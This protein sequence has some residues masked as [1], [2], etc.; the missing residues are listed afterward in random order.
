MQDLYK[1]GRYFFA[2]TIIA[3]GVI[4]FITRNFMTGFLPV[5]DDL[6]GR[7]FFLYVVSTLFLAG[8]ILMFPSRTSRRISILIG[9]LF[10]VFLVYPDLVRLFSDLHQPNSWTDIAETLGLGGGAFMIAGDYS[11][12][13]ASI[14]NEPL[15]PK[16]MRVGTIM[17][18]IG[19]LIVAVQHFMYA[20]FIGTLIPAWIP[21]PVF[22]AYF[23]GVAFAA[24]CISLLINIKTKLACILLGLMFLFWVVFL[25]GPRAFTNAHKEAEW[26][27]LF[28]ALGFSGVFF[29]IVS[30]YERKV[31]A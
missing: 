26:S 27:S 7:I 1:S 25:H 18:A 6:P 30:Q 20:D 29:T 23:V 31:I 28:M 10:M 3:F 9:I 12:G 14:K 8:G 24:T 13:I 22:W 19:L 2:I 16:L 11:N 5:H 4:Q 17:L 15:F 21:F